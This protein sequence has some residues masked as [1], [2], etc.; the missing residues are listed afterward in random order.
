MVR[1]LDPHSIFFD[2]GQFDQLRKMES[3]TQKGFGSVVS[4]VPGRVVVLQTLPGTPSA[5]A[6]LTPGDEILAINNYVIGRLDMDQLSELLTES[7]QHP[8]QLDVMRP[9]ASG[10]MRMVLVPEEMQSSTWIVRFFIGPG[11]GYI[12][13][14]SF[15]ENNTGKDL[16]DAIEKLGG[17]KMSG[18]VLDL[19]DNPGGV[20]TAA[21]ETASLFL[22]PAQT[23]FT[24]RGRSV[25]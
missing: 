22:Q 23:I 5:K 21:L 25:P 10:M 2:P 12:H 8:A 20:V 19:R 17:N 16:K 24:I 15:D 1:K 11:I 7:R 9:G 13:A 4:L 3:S 14:T 6:G 18:L